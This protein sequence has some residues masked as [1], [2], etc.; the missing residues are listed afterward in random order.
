M[1]LGFLLCAPLGP[2]GILCVQRTLASGRLSGAL[3]V[4]GAAVVDALYALLAA[5]GVSLMG[6]V[7]DPSTPW[8]NAV[9]GLILALVGTR[10]FLEMPPPPAAPADRGNHRWEAF[11]TTF[12]VMIS[13][14][15]PV[16]VISAALSA[17]NGPGASGVGIPLLVA[18]VFA[19]SA[20]WAPILVLG[21]SRIAPL[22]N[23]RHL[24]LAQRVCG[25]VLLA[26]GL[27]IGG[28]ALVSGLR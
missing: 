24:R 2:V 13:N 19:G 28:E 20:L 26:G 21:V 7:R 27:A 6:A 16:V 4:L 14:P 18:G 17:Q 3:S 22:L 11:L 15:I 9:A 23:G 8:V 10:V 1:V 25:A 5:L 12:F